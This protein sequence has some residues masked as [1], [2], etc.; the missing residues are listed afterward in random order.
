M[1]FNYRRAQRT[2]AAR[3]LQGVFCA[4]YLD[5]RFREIT[6]VME[7][8]HADRLGPL[9]ERRAKDA[10]VPVTE[11]DQVLLEQLSLLNVDRHACRSAAYDVGQ[12][13][14]RWCQKRSWRT[15]YF[16]KPLAGF[17]PSVVSMTTGGL[18]RRG[19]RG[20]ECA[21]LRDCNVNVDD[22]QTDLGGQTRVARPPGWRHL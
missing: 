16:R 11:D 22:I 3:W 10:H 1:L 15:D 2:E 7:Y 5:D 18:L 6:L 8:H 4:F 12:R 17:M 9:L 20:D 13:V 14:G 21:H 19:D